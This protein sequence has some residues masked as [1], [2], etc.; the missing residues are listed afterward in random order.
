[1]ATMPARASKREA[2]DKVITWLSDEGFPKVEVEPNGTRVY[3][4]VF[5]MIDESLFFV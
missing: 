3:A 5:P 1:M 2:F 4:K